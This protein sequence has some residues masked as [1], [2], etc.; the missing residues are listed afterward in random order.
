MYE[1]V[2]FHIDVKPISISFK[3]PHCRNYVKVP[4][5][6]VDDPRVGKMTGGV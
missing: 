6:S 4:W 2:D 1:G 3:C 5:H